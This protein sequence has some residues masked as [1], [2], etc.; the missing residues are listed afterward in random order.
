MSSHSELVATFQSVVGGIAVHLV[1]LNAEAG[2]SKVLMVYNELSKLYSF[3][4]KLSPPD[5]VEATGVVA[6]HIHPEVQTSLIAEANFHRLLHVATF[7]IPG[8]GTFRFEG[9]RWI[10]VHTTLRDMLRDGAS[11][12][13]LWRHIPRVKA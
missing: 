13:R 9:E 1:K 10:D 4:F 11:L 5:S 12:K 2:T 6:M 8:H 3:P 7:Q